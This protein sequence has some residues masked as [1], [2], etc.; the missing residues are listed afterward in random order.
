MSLRTGGT[1]GRTG[2]A[3]S[4][5]SGGQMNLLNPKLVCCISPCVR[6]QTRID[7]LK[8]GMEMTGTINRLMLLHGAQV[9]IG[10]EYD[11]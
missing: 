1:L 7:E 10:A 6:S 9:D 3:E 4:A 5:L 8:P 2:C 11:G